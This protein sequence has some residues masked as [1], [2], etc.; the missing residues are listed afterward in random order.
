MAARERARRRLLELNR[1][2]AERDARIEQAGTA[3]L[4]AVERRAAADAAVKIATAELTSALH[5][6]AAEG[7]TV[8]AAASV[9]GID[10][11]EARRLLRRSPRAAAKVGALAGNSVPNGDRPDGDAKLCF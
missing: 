3:G 4:L 2:R 1:D 5:G 11:A 8:D 6:L 10:V 9:V 7:I